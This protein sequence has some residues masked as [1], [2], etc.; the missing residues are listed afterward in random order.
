MLF[1]YLSNV[2]GIAQPRTQG[3]FLKIGRR[4]EPGIT[5]T[6]IDQERNLSYKTASCNDLSR[7][8]TNTL[9]LC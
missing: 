4:D 5:M 8:K 7:L 9:K 1:T 3:R 6:T 2:V